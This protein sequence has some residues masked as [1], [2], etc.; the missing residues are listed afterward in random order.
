MNALWLRAFR[1]VALTGS[2]TAAARALHITQPTVSEQVRAL[3]RQYGV[4]LVSRRGRSTAL[5]PLGHELLA[6]TERMADLDTEAEQCLRAA[7]GLSGGRVRFG[8]DAPMHA[9]PLLA[10]FTHRYPQVAVSL[11]SGNS[12]QVLAYLLEHRVDVAVVAD[13]ASDT[14]L[15]AVPLH[16]D[17]LVAVVPR[18]HRLASRSRLSVT[19]LAA[20]R[21]VLREPGSTT[22]RLVEQA[23]QAAG[24]QPE[25]TLQVD[26]REAMHA[27]VAAGLGVAAV[28]SS[29]VSR[30]ARIR[31]IPLTGPPLTFTQ[32]LA[33]LA[34]RRS[35]R[36][37]EAV[38]GAARAT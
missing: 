1:A 16:R 5:T 28:A 14:R 23:L 7:G 37:T 11:L 31:A 17:R 30:D 27:A 29:E 33:C 18:D 3:E 32:Y 9:M 21:M 34:E 12:S 25:E 35:A 10:R 8:S 20:E 36:L 2:F 22:R 26:N 13:V 19:A 4:T 6:I 24:R 38:F 15:A